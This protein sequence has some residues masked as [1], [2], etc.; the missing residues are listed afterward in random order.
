MGTGYTRQSAAEIADGQDIIAAPLNAEFNAL[1]NA[2]DDSIGHSHDGTVGEGPMI[3]L[4]TSITGVLPVANGGVGGINNYSASTAPGVGDDSADGYAVGSEWINLV[5]D[6]HYTC[7]DAT[8]GAAQW[9]EMVDTSTAQTLTNKTIILKQGTAPTPTVEG[10]VQWDTDD[11]VIVVGDGVGA[12]SFLDKDKLVQVGAVDQ[13]IAGAKKFTGGTI[14]VGASPNP[15]VTF[16]ILGRISYNGGAYSTI[17]TAS[18]DGSGSGLDA[19]LLDGQEGA[20]YL[21]AGSYTA[22]D[23]LTKIK[24][25]DGSGSGLDSDLLDGQ[26]GAYYLPASSY[27]AADVLTKI[28]TVDGTGTGLD[29]DLL[30]GQEGNYYLPASSYTAADVFAKVLTLD[31]P[32]SGLNADLLDGLSSASFQGALGF[33]PV[34]QGGFGG[35]GSDKVYLGYNPSVTALVA[36]VNVSDFGIVWTDWSTPRSGFGSASGYQKLG[37][38]LIIQWGFYGGGG[39]TTI[40]FPIVFPTSCRTVY[41]TIRNSDTATTE[42]YSAHVGDVGND[43]FIVRP[44]YAANG[45]IVGVATQA[46]NWFAIGY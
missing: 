30:D 2:F 13:D 32:G 41:T 7:V 19:D 37:S 5:T 23:V 45:G 12:K 40:Y 27:T 15:Y 29:A 44:R 9:S 39:D 14:Q 22:A 43:A 31:G 3:D 1:R 26:E 4:A 24:T 25:V 20:Y 6:K 21:P 33:T 17:W 16:D 35:M 10:D 11:N 42:A 28:K 34:Q 38:G 8:V 46:L 36:A 18:V